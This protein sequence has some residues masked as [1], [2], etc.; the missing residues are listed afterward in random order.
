MLVICH[1]KV[2]NRVE[3]T[4]FLAIPTDLKLMEQFNANAPFMH[5]SNCDYKVIDYNGD[6]PNSLQVSM[7][8]CTW[9]IPPDRSGKLGE[10]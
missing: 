6:I 5:I 4:A 7:N 3:G 10:D 8:P 1:D 9:H 2:S